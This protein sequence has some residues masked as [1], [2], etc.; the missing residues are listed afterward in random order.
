M[1]NTRS[2]SKNFTGQKSKYMLYESDVVKD[3]VEGREMMQST[4][5]DTKDLLG[6]TQESS[7]RGTRGLYKILSVI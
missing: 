1:P 3:N 2:K 4:R 7:Q 5:N 6:N